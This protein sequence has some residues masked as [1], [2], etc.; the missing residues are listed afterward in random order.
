MNGKFKLILEIIIAFF[1]I[2]GGVYT[3]LEVFA[4]NTDLQLVS[5]RLDRKILQ[6]RLYDL[7]E[8]IWKYEDRYG[9][10]CEKCDDVSKDE[11]RRLQQNLREIER[12][13]EGK[14]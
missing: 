14:T 1:V 10:D 2:A 9:R 7:Q 6:D 3:S 11:Y 8:R 12:Q 13:L 4:K 5:E